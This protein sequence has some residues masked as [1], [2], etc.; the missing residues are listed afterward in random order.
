MD[1]YLL[2]SISRRSVDVV[3]KKKSRSSKT[4]SKRKTG[5]PLSLLESKKSP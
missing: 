5:K 1:L 2:R 3:R 4:Y